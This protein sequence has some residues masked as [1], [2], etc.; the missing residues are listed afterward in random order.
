MPQRALWIGAVCC[1]LLSSGCSWRIGERQRAVAVNPPP[2]PTLNLRTRRAVKILAACAF[3]EAILGAINGKSGAEDL[4]PRVRRSARVC[5]AAAF[6]LT[7]DQVR[8][9]ER[10]GRAARRAA[11]LF[12]RTLS[13]SA[14]ALDDTDVARAQRLRRAFRRA[15]AAVNVA[16]RLINRRRREAGLRPLDPAEVLFSS[17]PAR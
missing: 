9:F 3:Q 5:R 1:V 4:A 6:G 2:L 8:G 16:V 13:A 11:L 14:D 17:L 7:G 15:D 12:A 10:G